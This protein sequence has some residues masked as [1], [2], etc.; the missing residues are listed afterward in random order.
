M[1]YCEICDEVICECNKVIID[2]VGV[3]NKLHRCEPHK[4]TTKCG[5]KVK[6]KK[7]VKRG[8]LHGCYECTY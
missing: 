8:E 2:C 6:S 7:D 5:I 4:N 3:D 1:A